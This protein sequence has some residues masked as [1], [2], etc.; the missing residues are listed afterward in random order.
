MSIDVDTELLPCTGQET[1][2]KHI[3]PARQ[4]VEH[5]LALGYRHVQS[6]AA[7]ATVGVLDVG[8]WVAFDAQH[9]GLPKSALRVAGHRVL[10]LDH[11]GAPFDQHRACR[12]DEPVHGDF[13]NAD[14]LQWP[15][16]GAPRPHGRDSKA[17]RSKDSS[18]PATPISRPSC[19]GIR[20]PSVVTVTKISF[21]SSGESYIR[22]SRIQE[23]L[24]NEIDRL[25]SGA[26]AHTPVAL[27]LSAQDERGFRGYVA[28]HS[29]VR[30]RFS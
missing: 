1:G 10:D 26:I 6:D 18:S 27:G 28:R 22:V 25:T 8:V 5:F 15:H 11:I 24:R 23:I 30:V 4:L 19:G 9:A 7:L 14:A 29:G 17:L 2:Q 12:W 21:S 13:Q 3:G 16:A 20:L